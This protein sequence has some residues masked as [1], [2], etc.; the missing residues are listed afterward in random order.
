MAFCWLSC[1]E[2]SSLYSFGYNL[3]IA[4]Q[5]RCQPSVLTD[6][7]LGGSLSTLDPALTIA[8]TYTVNA[9]GLAFLERERAPTAPHN[10]LSRKWTLC[11]ETEHAPLIGRATGTAIDLAEDAGSGARTLVRSCALSRGPEGSGLKSALLNSTAGLEGANAR[12]KGPVANPGR[13]CTWLPFCPLHS[14]L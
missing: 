5:L 13:L 7:S 4:K 12:A 8:R 6:L 10:A 9:H 11:L 3:P 1:Q 2:N 14:L